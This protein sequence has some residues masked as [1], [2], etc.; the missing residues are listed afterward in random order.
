YNWHAVN[1]PRGLAPAGWHIPSKEEWETL[2]N[3]LGGAAIAGGKLKESGTI[4]WTPF[5]TGATNESGFTAL[6]GLGRSAVQGVFLGILGAYR[7]GYWWT[8]NK[9]FEHYIIKHMDYASTEVSEIA[10]AATFGASVRCI[11]DVPPSK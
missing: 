6:P 8:T 7:D 11:K 1:D 3:C 5:N 4:H 9:V 10:Q 2:I